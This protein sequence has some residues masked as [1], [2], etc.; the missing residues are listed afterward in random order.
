MLTQQPGSVYQI[1]YIV[2]SLEAAA[3]QW[4]EL[5]G[6]GPFVVFEHFQFIEPVYRGVPTDLDVSIALGFT[7]G[8][9]LELI[10]QH[11]ER[12]S[13]YHDW[14]MEHG[15][16]LH[17]VA[18]LVEDFP[19]ALKTHEERGAPAVF[20]AA[21]GDGTRLAYLDSRRAM[22][23]Y[24]EL[25]EFTDFVQNALTGMRHDHDSWDGSDLLRPFAI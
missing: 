24:L 6:A 15:Y 13:I 19:A 10:E 1:A 2:P 12:P 9:C 21:F 3:R 23:C 22:N 11:D 7:A 25:V 5:T 14:R 17:H 16:G 4:S 8:L 20:R 18:M